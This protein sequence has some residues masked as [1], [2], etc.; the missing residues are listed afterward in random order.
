MLNFLPEGQRSFWEMIMIP[1]LRSTM[2]IL[3]I[4]TILAT[5]LGLLI[6]VIL[7]V[8]CKD[9]IRPNKVI[10]GIVDFVVNVIRSFPFII[11]MVF[12]LPFTKSI[13]GTSFG[14]KAALVPITVSATA[15]IAK[16]IEG[17]MKEV[18]PQL[19]EAMRSFGISDFHLIFGVMLSEA[20]PAIISGV[21]IATIAILGSTAMAGTMG[22]G[23][24][25]S[26]AVTYGYQSFNKKVMF[27]TTIILIFMVQSIQL[28]G[29]CVYKKMKKDV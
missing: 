17:A 26:V 3:I 10:Y 15:F 16:L 7:I 12:L 28:I 9:G 8:T 11:L 19:V 23:G 1:A 18:D 22:A 20:L 13:V 25:G 5:I 21:I 2:Q 4:A 27:T 29:N 6:A 14:V 24:I